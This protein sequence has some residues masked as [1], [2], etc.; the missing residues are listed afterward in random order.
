L[1]HV[2]SPVRIL[3]NA[4]A[5]SP[6][7]NPGEGTQRFQSYL[8]A[9]R[10]NFIAFGLHLCKPICCPRDSTGVREQF[11]T[12]TSRLFR[13]LARFLPWARGKPF[14]EPQC[15]KMRTASDRFMDSPENPQLDHMERS[16][17]AEIAGPGRPLAC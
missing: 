15:R 4:W 6:F 16:L 3:R 13:D 14:N 11:L 12:N 10:R 1:R 9:R 17:I 7:N 2:S 8:C 5:A